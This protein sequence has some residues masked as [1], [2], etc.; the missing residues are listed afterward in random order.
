MTERPILGQMAAVVISVT[1]SFLRVLSPR[2]LCLLLSLGLLVG[3]SKDD[4]DDDR[5]LA[6][7]TGS[8]AGNPANV[9]GQNSG[10]GGSKGTAGAS[11]MAGSNSGPSDFPDARVYVDAHNAVRAA[12]Q[13]PANYS[14]N[15]APVP[16]VTWSDEVATTAQAWAEQ[17]RDTMACRLMHASGTGYGE[18]LAGGTNVDAA[19][20]VAMWASEEENYS[21]SPKYEFEINTGHYTQIVWRKTTQIGCGRATCGNGAVVACRYSP[22]GNYIGQAPY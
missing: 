18:N 12:V 9:G 5:H 8:A 2:S 10:T 1:R 17:L 3:C 19:R 22:P 15:W 11:A 14:G 16:P 13:K 6:A 21:Y 4:A 20:A 7:G